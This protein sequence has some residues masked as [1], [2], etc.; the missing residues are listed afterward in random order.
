M[1]LYDIDESVAYYQCQRCTECCKWPGDVVLEEADLEAISAFLDMSVYDFV[2]E[3]TDLRANRTGLTLKEHP[4]TT[5]CIFLN[6]RDC[7]INPVKP[8]Q[9]AGF[10][11]EWNFKDWRKS[12]EAKPIYHQDTT[13]K[14]K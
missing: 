12:C 2:A 3:Y 4:E 14:N 10:P 5:T 8:K 7:A 9:C 6:G 1:P 11:N 13:P